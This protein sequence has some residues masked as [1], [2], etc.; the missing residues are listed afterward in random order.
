MAHLADAIHPVPHAGLSLGSQVICALRCL[1]IKHI[2]KLLFAIL[3]T[4][5]AVD[6]LALIQIDD[7]LQL[8]TILIRVVFKAE[9]LRYLTLFQC[10]PASAPALEKKQQIESC[11]Q[12]SHDKTTLPSNGIAQRAVQPDR[13]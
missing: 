10:E 8:A 3:E 9:L 2:L 4:Q 6:L 13:Q 1:D 7:T 5:T 11:S 12:F